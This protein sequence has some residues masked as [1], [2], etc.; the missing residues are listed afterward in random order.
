MS[1]AKLYQNLYEIEVLEGLKSFANEELVKRLS[2]KLKILQSKPTWLLVDYPEDPNDF[3]KIATIVA[4]YRVDYFDVP[5]PKA[6]LGHANLTQVMAI[7]RQVLA[8]HPAGSFQ[9]FRFSAAGRDSAVFARLQEAIASTLK[10]QPNAE[11]GDLFLRFR[12]AILQESGWEMLVRLTPR[13]L[14]TRFWRV[15]DMRGAVNATIAASMVELTEP[16]K[17]DRVI[18]LM[19]GSG[20]LMVERALRG[21]FQSIV[22]VEHDPKAL[23]CAEQNIAAAR[24]QNHLELMQVDATQTGLP[25]NIFDSLLIDLPWGQA[26]G[27]HDYNAGL[28]PRVLA[29]VA[30]IAKPRSRFV[31]LSHEVNL[32]EKILRETPH[33][34]VV[35][36]SFKVFQGGL[37]PRIFLLEKR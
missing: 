17:R 27:T 21:P 30:R 20:T 24:L 19:S 10:L 32:M 9:T 23:A 1:Q 37:H 33:G 7:L 26:V 3:F 25:D 28:Y 4:V 18:N 34:W 15:C 13:P 12:R 11:E 36:R 5:R 6:L 16:N 35:K 8:L 14:S 22:G 31:I 29:E 2:K